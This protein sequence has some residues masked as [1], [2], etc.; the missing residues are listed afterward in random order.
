[1]MD[2]LQ[3]QKN[4]KRLTRTMDA[5]SRKDAEFTSLAQDLMKRDHQSALKLS[6]VV[7]PERVVPK[8]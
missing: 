7:D 3:P 2:V 1:M 4:R 5:L 6:F 8:H